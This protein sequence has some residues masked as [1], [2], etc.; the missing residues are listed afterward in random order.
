MPLNTYVQR[1]I[2]DALSDLPRYG[3]QC[4][5]Y[6]TEAEQFAATLPYL[7]DGLRTG[8]YC[9]YIVDEHTGESMRQ[10]MYQNEIEVDDAMKSG[11]LALLTKQETYL[12][13]GHF[14]AGRMIE[15]VKAACQQAL[16]AG[17]PGVRGAG[18]MTWHLGSDATLQ[19]LL[20]YESR[21]T[22]EIFCRFPLMGICQYN[23]NR[24]NPEFL[25]GILETH[26]VVIYKDVVCENYFYIPREE[27][28]AE[29]V[30]SRA[31]LVRRLKTIRENARQHHALV[32]ALEA[33]K[34]A[35]AQAFE[36]LGELEYFQDVTVGRELRMIALEKQV[37][38]LQSR[39]SELQHR[40]QAGHA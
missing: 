35:E 5:I 9:F 37:S 39:L 18:E 21:L 25:R 23:L 33:R 22:D 4:L 2:I 38:D 24:F 19:E 10:A 1:S 27:F 13:D 16:M 17:F 26:P 36:R 6:E 11:Q 32:S 12:R 8:Q 34:E 3:H 20:T 7:R 14:N 29:Q 15:F 28:L 30:D 31:Q 40:Q